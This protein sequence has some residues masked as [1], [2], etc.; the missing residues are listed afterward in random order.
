MPTTSKGLRY[1]AST[2]APTGHQQIKDLADD[3]NARISPSP[4]PWI[5]CYLRRSDGQNLLNPGV[6]TDLKVYPITGQ[7]S[8]TWNT[9]VS[10]RGLSNTT[11][12]WWGV[13]AKIITS[14]SAN[15]YEA[16]GLSGTV[17]MENIGIPAF[18][19][20]PGFGGAGGFEAFAAPAGLS[21]LMNA[22]TSAALEVDLRLDS[23]SNPMSRVRVVYLGPI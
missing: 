3:V 20:G 17:T 18:S 21:L 13:M 23:G 2:D 15:R 9:N 6:F 8:G 12:G 4:R 10:G 14:H 7:V 16:V 1:P 5:E 22:Y 19:A 11:P